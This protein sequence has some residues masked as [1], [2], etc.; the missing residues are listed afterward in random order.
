M[1]RTLSI[2]TR[3]LIP[4]SGILVVAF[5][6]LIFI[7]YGEI[8]SVTKDFAFRQASNISSEL[9]ADITGKLNQGL[10]AA[11]TAAAALQPFRRRAGDGRDLADA[12]LSAVLS[13]NPEHISIGTAWEANAFDKADAKSAARKDSD[14]TGRLGLVISRTQGAGTQ[15]A[16][17]PEI[18]RQDWYALARRVKAP[19]ITDPVL[20]VGRPAEE[21]TAFCSAPVLDDG[22]FA[23]AVA[24]QFNLKSVRE[25]IARARPLGTGIAMLYSN[26]GMILAHNDPTR[27]GQS[28]RSTET[29]ILGDSLEAL[30]R[31]VGAGEPLSLTVDS[32]LLH[33][34]SLVS[35]TPMRVGA[36]GAPWSL[37]VAVPLKSVLGKQT[38]LLLF[39]IAMGAGTLLLVILAVVG[40][41]ALVVRPIRRTA[42]I[43]EDVAE[44]EGDL[45][46]RLPAGGVDEI[47][48]MSRH[49]NAF[50]DKLRDIVASLRGAGASLEETGRNL[51]QSMATTASAV[52]QIAA[53]ARSI[54][55][56][57]LSQAASVSES[58]GEVERMA[59]TIQ[60]LDGRIEEQS[61]GISES[62]ASVEEMVA[63][64]ESVARNIERLGQSF[65]SL[66]GA[67][68]SGRATLS[69]LNGRI[70]EIATQSETLMETNQVIAGVASQ[71]NLLAMNAAIEAAH[72]G[73]AGRGFSVVA[74]EIRKLAEMS[75]SRAKA[76]AK[77]LRS[78][79][80]TIDLMVGSSSSAEREFGIILD[81]IR[82]LDGLRREIE[83][84]ME[85]QRS[86]SSR[87]LEA[88]ER[89]NASTR[90]IRAGSSEMADG[91]KT[92]LK[93]ME[94]LLGLT[95]EIRAGMG[96]I[97]RGA[98]DIDAA[99]HSVR[100]LAATNS[101]HIA[102]VVEA[103]AKF[104]IDSGAGDRIAA[105]GEEAD[106]D[107]PAELPAVD[108]YEL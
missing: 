107:A 96:E 100:E 76:T 74:D 22:V 44:G 64:V 33:S 17:I 61:A 83:S 68:E 9:A 24:V 1:F 103:A 90:E 8:S 81:L 73:E 92:V 104:R 21:M 28:L 82:A 12:V 60:S 37:A 77:E 41:S 38:S 101:A 71:T 99:V 46:R 4:I 30:S 13:A 18:E 62:S 70:R 53:S 58:T 85:E 66:L 87:V 106:R 31:A 94:S 88:L 59:T 97:A 52:A 108:D 49:F 26:S 6:L 65:E 5:P 19:A 29:D 105:Q 56:R 43:L 63:N 32:K 51:T 40:L 47:G 79:K 98:G 80:S 11:Q 3:L 23:G 89:M 20:P 69:E 45:T 72:A 50:M 35:V 34:I 67:S 91:G 75:A 27:V 95:E 57:V 10:E 78:I 48:R 42:D 39:M 36:S 7:I 16:G 15:L 25:V 14:R 55:E 2:R 86:G 102:R 54:N 84:A 93:E